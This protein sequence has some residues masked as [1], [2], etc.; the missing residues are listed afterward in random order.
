MGLCISI[1]KI[2]EDSH[3]ARYRFEGDGGN[4]GVFEIE[5]ESGKTV[6]VI[7]MLGDD[8]GRSF[9]AASWKISKSWKSGVFPE[10]AQF[11]S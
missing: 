8:S 6:L 9:G 4:A 2:A 7:P 10:A 3:S 1:K 11:A 5:K